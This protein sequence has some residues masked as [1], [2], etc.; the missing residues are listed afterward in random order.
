MIFL[1]VF[2]I[3]H[4]TAN[5]NNQIQIIKNVFWIPMIPESPPNTRIPTILPSIATNCST[6]VI[7]PVSFACV[8]FD[9]RLEITGLIIDN[10]NEIPKEIIMIHHKDS[11]KPNEANNNDKNN[12]TIKINIFLS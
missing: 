2:T 8:D 12:K 3:I 1:L 4:Q 7:L 6:Q 10:P 5:I 9:I 11:L